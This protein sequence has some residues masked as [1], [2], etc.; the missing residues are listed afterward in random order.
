MQV[1]IALRIGAI[2][3]A[4]VAYVAGS[5]WLMTQTEGSAW[6]VVVV[7]TPMLIA[8]A[9]GCWR[10]GQR[11]MA[12]ISVLALAALCAQ[13]VLGVQVPAHVLYLSQHVG[14]NLFLAAFFGSTLR[15]GHTALITTLATRVHGGY[16]IPSM[17]V[18]TRNLTRAWAIFFVVT[19]LLSLLLF[20][21][22]S[23]E[24]W[25]IFAN[26]V[27]PISVVLMFGIEY[28]IRY[29]LHPEFERSSVADAVRAYMHGPKPPA[30]PD[31]AS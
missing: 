12:G 25:A 1:R 29:R 22:A 27:S 11:L 30:Q 16:L 5:H 24:A 7:L 28:L 20:F 18:Y 15:P 17:A 14:F 10:G 13:A 19:V 26:W 31:S 21:G 3:L 2:A 9:V 8:I 23:F 6:N 4:A